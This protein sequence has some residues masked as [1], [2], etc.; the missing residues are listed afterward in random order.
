MKTVRLQRDFVVEVIPSYALPVAK[1]YGEAFAALCVEA[2]EEVDQ[3]WY[4]DGESFV[5]PEKAPTLPSAPT[6]EERIAALEEN[7]ADRAEVDAITAAIEKGL[8]L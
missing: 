5:P 7:K 2:P 3:G 4:F 1:W 8:S 6:P